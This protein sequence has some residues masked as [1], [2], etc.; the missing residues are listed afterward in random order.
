MKNLPTGNEE[1]EKS[2]SELL[3][4]VKKTVSPETLNFV[5]KGMGRL[6]KAESKKALC[7]AFGRGLLIPVLQNGKYGYMKTKLGNTIGKCL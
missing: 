4:S 3:E 6:S 5:F 2:L 7:E 1:N